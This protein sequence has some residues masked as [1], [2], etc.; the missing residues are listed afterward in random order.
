MEGTDKLR[1]YIDQDIKEEERSST[2]QWL[3]SL[4]D[5]ELENLL[6]A[7]WEETPIPMPA[8]TATILDMQLKNAGIPLTAT[9]PFRVLRLVRRLVA[10]A[11]IL[12]LASLYFLQKHKPAAPPTTP[13]TQLANTSMHARKVTLPDSSLVWLSPGAA[14]TIPANYNTQSR[15]ISISGEG[16]FEVAPHTTPFRVFAGGLEAQVLG[17][18][19]NVEAYP[20]ERT[21]TIALTAGSIA[22]RIRPDSAV[23]LKPGFKL[24]SRPAFHQVTVRNFLKE[25]ES[26][27]KKGA[28]VLDDV[29]LD[30]VFSRLEYRYHKKVIINANFSG[31]ARFTGAFSNTNLEDMLTNMAFVYGFKWQIA[32]DT[33]FIH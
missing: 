23:V 10:A 13:P 30:A 9:K 11:S 5:H 22:I 15:N 7:G 12:L 29:P 19:F 26:D 6:A 17:T 25:R 28:F 16:Y 2:H 18:H 32:N 4:S 1:N 33:V 14:L 24:I 8:A 27:W 20:A 21:T 3:Q 31:K